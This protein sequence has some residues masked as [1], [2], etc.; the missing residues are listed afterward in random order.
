LRAVVL[1]QQAPS[2]K[3][4]IAF[5]AEWFLFKDVSIVVWFALP[6]FLFDL[7]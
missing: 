1:N 3:N 2:G 7:L 4:Y 5:V 6:R